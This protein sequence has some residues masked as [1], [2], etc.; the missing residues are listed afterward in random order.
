[1]WL[2]SRGG[3]SGCEPGAAGYLAANARLD[4]PFSWDSG[5]RR[6]TSQA[7]PP[8]MTRKAQEPGRGRW[9]ERSGA[10]AR[11]MMEEERRAQT[12]QTLT[13]ICAPPVQRPLLSSPLAFP[14]DGKPRA[15]PWPPSIGQV[16]GA[17]PSL[18]AESPEGAFV[19]P[20][21]TSPQTACLMATVPGRRRSVED[22]RSLP[23]G[24]GGTPCLR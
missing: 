2:S 8:A 19:A 12:P 14:L 4:V 3:Q 20:P 6:R 16:G 18:W 11:S 1:L 22:A 24:Q 10:R 7:E 17:P 5:W 9:K 15:T 21:T 13:L 23:I